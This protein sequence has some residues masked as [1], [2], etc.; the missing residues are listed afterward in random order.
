M[1][2]TGGQA[3]TSLSAAPSVQ[4]A[5]GAA[6]TTTSTPAVASLAAGSSATLTW[7]YTENGSAPG[8]L[9]L[10]AA[11]SGTGGSGPVNASASTIAAVVQQPAALGAASLT[12]PDRLSADKTSRRP[13]R[14]RT[15]A[16]PPLRP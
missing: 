7:S 4:A 9:Q 2:N 10:A 3:I 12:L 13:Y 11:V 6:A 5:G 8:T 1:K 14:C 16:A 15:P